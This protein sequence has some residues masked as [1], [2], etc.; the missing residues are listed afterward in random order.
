M[1]CFLDNKLKIM[2]GCTECVCTY[3]H[4]TMVSRDNGALTQKMFAAPNKITF[5]IPLFRMCAH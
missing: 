2:H 1:K 3:A 4:T 5:T